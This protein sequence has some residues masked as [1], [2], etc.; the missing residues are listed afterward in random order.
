MRHIIL[1]IRDKRC[2]PFQRRTS[3]FTQL[4]NLENTNKC[5]VNNYN[6]TNR[7]LDNSSNLAKSLIISAYMRRNYCIII[8]MHISTKAVIL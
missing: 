6:R 2:F 5:F 3:N 7:I 8:I 4:V 1:R